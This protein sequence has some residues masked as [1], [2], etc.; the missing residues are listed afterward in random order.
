MLL[1]CVLL[2]LYMPLCIFV[3]QKKGYFLVIRDTFVLFNRAIIYKRCVIV[4]VLVLKTCALEFPMLY[5][6]G[7]GREN[8]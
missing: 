2:C 1:R 4:R 8:D 6:M 7:V 3:S 5:F